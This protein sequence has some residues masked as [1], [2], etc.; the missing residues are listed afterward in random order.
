MIKEDKMKKIILF[1]VLA[2]LLCQGTY[3]FAQNIPKFQESEYYYFSFP[4]DKIYSHRLGFMVIYRRNSNN[5]ARTFI[6]HEWFG[7][8]DSKGEVIY[9]GTG[10]EMPSMIVYYKNGEFSHVRL[11]LRRNRLHETWG[12]VP[13]NVGL[14]EYFE[15]V[16][17]VKLEH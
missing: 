11:R 13:M 6:P 5:S 12:V 3:L 8:V 7:T 4:I 9:L 10:T 17:E 2:A 1:V 14:D 15:G 16:E